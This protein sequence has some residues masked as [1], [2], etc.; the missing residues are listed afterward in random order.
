MRSESMCT[1]KLKV[2]NQTTMDYTLTNQTIRV[3]T[4]FFCF[5]K[6]YFRIS[7]ILG[8]KKKKN[9]DLVYKQ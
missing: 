1:P 8:K 4:I 9:S 5:T 2:W 6:R 3:P 7:G